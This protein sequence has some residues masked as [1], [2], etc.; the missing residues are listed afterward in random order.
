MTKY[1]SSSQKTKLLSS[2]A[3][4][5]DL[6]CATVAMA[7]ACFGIFIA[8]YIGTVLVSLVFSFFDLYAA[9]VSTNARS[10][11]LG[12]CILINLWDI[13]LF[14]FV[15]AVV[16]VS[17]WSKREGK[18]TSFLLHK[19]LHY[20]DDYATEK[21]VTKSFSATRKSDKYF[22]RSVVSSSS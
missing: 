5:H 1:D 6:L 19:A 17:S 18:A 3:S 8:A 9:L 7:N 20:Q 4:L 13:F 11:E 2:L 10:E 16:C 14:T 22:F 15:F 12:Y 21:R